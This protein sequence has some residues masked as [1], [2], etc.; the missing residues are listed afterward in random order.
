MSQS[1]HLKQ[2]LKGQGLAV[3]KSREPKITKLPTRI[4]V[5]C[6]QCRRQ[7]TVFINLADVD[8]L[9]CRECGNRSPTVFGRNPMQ[10]WSRQRRVA[11]AR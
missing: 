8:K 3:S 7:A 5:R 11:N 9:V 6:P 2:F 10:V 4:E 1:E